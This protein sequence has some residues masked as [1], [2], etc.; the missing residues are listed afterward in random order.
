MQAELIMCRRKCCPAASPLRAWHA[1][2][3]L[4]QWLNRVQLNRN[5][6][7]PVVHAVAQGV[8]ATGQ[9]P[10]AWSQAAVSAVFKKGDPQ[11]HTNYR[12]IAVGNILGKVFSMVLDARV[13]SW[14]EQH[15]LR[16]RGQAGFRKGMRTTDQLFVLRHLLAKYKDSKRKLY[17]CFVDFEKAYDS[18]RRDLLLQRLGRLGVCGNM[19]RAIACMYSAVPMCAR[20]EGKISSSFDS[21][22]GVKQGDPMSPLLFG[23]FLDGVE[24]H[25]AQCAGGTGVDIGGQPCQMLLYADDIVLL[26]SSARDLQRQ[27]TALSAF[28]SE[29]HMRINVQKTKVQWWAHPTCKCGG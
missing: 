20:S 21:E 19:L 26:A 7:L 5:V 6:L 17:M 24:K 2:G 12:G 3:C 28:C 16:A 14:C 10:V 11:Q 29:S 8:F 18:V 27:M 22:L 25:V 1:P 15:G 13:A 23:L 9:Y 4:L